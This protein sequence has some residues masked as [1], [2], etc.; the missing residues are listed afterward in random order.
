M[1]VRGHNLVWV[2]DQ[3]NLLPAFVRDETDAATL[4]KYML[5]YIHTVVTHVGEK[6][7][8]WDV[9]NE[10]VSDDPNQLIKD[11]PWSKIDDYLCK[12]FKAA[13][14]ANPKPLLFYNDYNIDSAVGWSKTKSDKVYSLVK[15]L[16]SRGC[17]V[18]GVG[19]QAHLTIDYSEEMVEGVREN[20]QRYEA[21][22]MDVHITELDIKCSSSK[23]CSDSDWTEEMRETQASLYAQLLKICLEEKACT[24]FETW[25][26]TDKYSWLATGQDGLPY[27]KEYKP[28]PA[29]DKIY[30][31]LIGEGEEAIE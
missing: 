28:K 3:S 24:S 12:A 25:G 29:Y 9:I 10:A 22:G 6:A 7:F 14:S 19:L 4:E 15:D 27:D 23:T 11:S 1:E 18:D 16:K 13:R 2:T 31:T 8:A 5:D 17:P 20:I 30:E 21:L 26:Y